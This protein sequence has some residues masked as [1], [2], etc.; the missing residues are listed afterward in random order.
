MI[1][2]WI[3]DPGDISLVEMGKLVYDVAIRQVA[4]LAAS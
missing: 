1:A 3:Q 2:S 4:A